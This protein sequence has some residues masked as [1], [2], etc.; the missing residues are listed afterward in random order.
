MSD[1]MKVMQNAKATG[2]FAGAKRSDEDAYFAFF[3]GSA[4][5]CDVTAKVSRLRAFWDAF[6]RGN[7]ATETDRPVFIRLNVKAMTGRT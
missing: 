4:P 1:W 3:E 5:I 2:H 6:R 7:F